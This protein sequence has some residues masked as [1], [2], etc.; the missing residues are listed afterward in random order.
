MTPANPFHAHLDT[1]AVCRSQPFNL[2]AEGVRLLV[3][4]VI[5]Q[6]I[7]RYKCKQRCVTTGQPAPATCKHGCEQEVA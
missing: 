6:P 5:V 2:C 7:T 4:A 1:C 3:A